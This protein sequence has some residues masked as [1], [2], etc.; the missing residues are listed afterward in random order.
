[1]LNHN[2]ESAGGTSCTSVIRRNKDAEQLE[3]VSEFL[4]QLQ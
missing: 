2:L 3:V 4:R 1:M